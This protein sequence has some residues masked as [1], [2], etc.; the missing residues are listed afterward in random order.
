MPEQGDRKLRRRERQ[1]KA[2]HAGAQA[3]RVTLRHRGDELS[4][5]GQGE[6]RG[7]PSDDGGHVTRQAECSQALIDAPPG[8]AP[9]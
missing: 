3:A 4:R 7:E 2:E 8:Q 5:A 6:C 1:R 9:P